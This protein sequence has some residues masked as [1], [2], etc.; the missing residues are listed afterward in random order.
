MAHINLQKHQT[1]DFYKQTR[2]FVCGHKL[3]L[4]VLYA[5]HVAHF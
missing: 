5:D 3:A 2:I 4:R 1:A